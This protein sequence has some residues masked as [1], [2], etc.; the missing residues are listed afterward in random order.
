MAQ[1]DAEKDGWMTRRGK[2]VAWKR[3][4][5]KILEEEV[6]SSSVMRTQSSTAQEMESVASRWAKNLHH[7][8]KVSAGSSWSLLSLPAY[9]SRC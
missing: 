4:L 7:V 2:G 3:I 9:C 8:Q 5:M 1:H 6:V